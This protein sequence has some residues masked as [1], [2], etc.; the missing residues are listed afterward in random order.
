VLQYILHRK[1]QR[2]THDLSTAIL[3]RVVHTFVDICCQC[4]EF[5]EAV[6]VY[7]YGV[8]CWEMMTGQEPWAHVTDPKELVS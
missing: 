7:S 2:V 1:L 4:K 6:D 3:G 5:N 8:L